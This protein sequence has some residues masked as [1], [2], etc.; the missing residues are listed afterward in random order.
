ML[1][2]TPV[3]IHNLLMYGF[4]KL[5]YA[6]KSFSAKDHTHPI[7]TYFPYQHLSERGVLRAWKEIM[8]H[9]ESNHHFVMLTY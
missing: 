1:F 7:N 6:P 9:V 8:P 3:V 4:P 2:A 5:I